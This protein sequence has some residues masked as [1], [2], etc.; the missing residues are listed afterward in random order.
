MKYFSTFLGL[1]F[2]EIQRGPSF[3]DGYKTQL[4]VGRMFLIRPVPRGSIVISNENR[5]LT[6]RNRQ[7]IAG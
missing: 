5:R 2:I 1:Y 4:P 3:G 6:G 7:S